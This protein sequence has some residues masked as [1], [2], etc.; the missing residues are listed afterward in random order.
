MPKMYKFDLF[1]SEKFI[2][3]PQLRKAAANPKVFFF[4]LITIL[5]V[6]QTAIAGIDG[7]GMPDAWE[8]MHDCL[9]PE[10]DDGQEDP[11][12]DGLTNIEELLLPFN[13]DPCNPDTDGDGMDD[14]F[15]SK[16]D[17]LQGDIA[18]GDMSGDWDHLTNLEE[19]LYSPLM[20]PCADDTDGDGVR[21]NEEVMAGSNPVLNHIFPNLKSNVKLM[22]YNESRTAVVYDVN[23]AFTGSEYGLSWINDQSND[24]YLNRISLDG[25]TIGPAIKFADR[26]DDLLNLKMIYTGS[27][28]VMMWSEGNLF[29]GDHELLLS[30]SSP[31]GEI[32]GSHPVLDGIYGEFESLDYL[33][34]WSIVYTGSEFGISAMMDI[35]DYAGEDLYF[36]RVSQTG[37]VLQALTRMVENR[38]DSNYPS[39]IYTGSEYGLSWHYGMTHNWEIYFARISASGEKVDTDAP[40]TMTIGGSVEPA[41]AFSGSEYAVVWRERHDTGNDE[42]YFKRISSIGR[43][44]GQDV[45]LTY[46]TGG[47]GPEMIF[48]GSEYGVIWDGYANGKK[49]LRFTWVSLSGEKTGHDYKISQ[50]DWA[51]V[52]DF[53]AVYSGS[54]YAVAWREYISDSHYVYFATL[55]DFDSDGDGLLDDEEP[56]LAGTEMQN[57][58][59]DDDGMDDG[60]EVESMWCGLDPLTADD[61]DDSDSDGEMNIE[62]YTNGNDPCENYDDDDDDDGD[63]DCDDGNDDC[64]DG[65]DDVPTKGCSMSVTGSLMGNLSYMLFLLVPFGVFMT[66]RSFRNKSNQV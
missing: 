15:E 33:H 35:D 59:T 19:Y 48:T 26:R 64:D 27:E 8:N 62:E 18:D 66:V 65:N 45:R 32:I 43:K 3:N 56:A 23:L 16:H 51:R 37:E 20:N 28:Y 39:L 11:D 30:R 52:Y 44:I 22:S 14:A 1:L 10:I 61:L 57:W 7:D 55:S 36:S 40:I 46:N 38:K 63:D 29:R 9:K 50:N 53:N 42:L 47:Q 25:E 24:I 31:I 58:D 60:W 2:S 6:S 12:G 49:R 13:F 21:D 4:A 54:E 41:L 17:C 5:L 34:N